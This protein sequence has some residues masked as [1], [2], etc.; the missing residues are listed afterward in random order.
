MTHFLFKKINKKSVI[1]S[2]LNIRFYTTRPA[3]DILKVYAQKKI[4]M[5]GLLCQEKVR[6]SYYV[7]QYY[8]NGNSGKLNIIT[9]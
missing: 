5:K 7:S 3:A 8:A 9:L 2:G 4:L 1:K 6:K